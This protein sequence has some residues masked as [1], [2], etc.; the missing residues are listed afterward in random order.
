MYVSV[1]FLY[2]PIK[3]MFK[4]KIHFYYKGKISLQF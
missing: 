2:F 1:I 3:M 4:N